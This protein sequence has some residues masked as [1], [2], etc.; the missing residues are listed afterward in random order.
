MVRR[1]WLPILVV[2][3][4]AAAARP[5]M[6]ATNVPVAAGAPAGAIE[7]P[8]APARLR[9][10]T[11]NVAWLDRAEGA[12]HVRRS[13]ADYERLRRYAAGLDADVVAL[14]EIDGPGAARRLFDSAAWDLHLTGD[15][16]NPQRTGFVF[17]R[18]LRVT[19]NPDLVELALGRR[20]RGA[21]MTVHLAGG[22]LRLLGVH[23][24][25]G[26]QHDA[27]SSGREECAILR[28]QLAILEGWIDARAREPVAFA[29]VGDFNRQFEPPDR[30][31]AEI[32]DGEP[33]EAD[34]VAVT[35]GRRPVCWG[36]RYPT[37]IDHI[38]LSR[39]AAGWL[40]PGSFRAIDYAGADARFEAVLSDHCPLEVT[41][42]TAQPPPGPPSRLRAEEAVD[43]AGETATVCGR[44]AGASFARSVRGQP[45]FLNLDRPHPDQPFSVVIW[46]DDRPA[47]GEPE[48]SFA[49]R[50]ICATGLIRLHKGKPEIV[51]RRPDEIAVGPESGPPPGGQP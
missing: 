15:V 12:G 9:L 32:D 26:C 44:V 22:D 43:H 51:V 1:S 38:V 36:G 34:L 24:K 13:A 37:F 39:T 8:A 18:G 33:P 50:R 49:G 14:Q 11:W 46:G 47:F 41:I 29:V 31:W 19:R 23:L 21:D 10:A 16:E 48:R 4:T 45:T 7:R 25:S 40:V 27:L 42:D 3:A 35:E 30:F 20:R 6:H 28:R 17:R 2:L 5:A